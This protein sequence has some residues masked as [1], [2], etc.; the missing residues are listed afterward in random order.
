MDKPNDGDHRTN[1][2][3]RTLMSGTIVYQNDNC[4][5]PCTIPDLSDEGAKLRPLDT[6]LLPEFF[7]LKITHR[8]FYDCEV[9]HRER[10]RIGVQFI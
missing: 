8:Q 4:T 9:V 1:A 10:D 3:K 7:R 5:M 2:R 6:T